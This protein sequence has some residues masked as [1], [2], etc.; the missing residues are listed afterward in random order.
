MSLH[1]EFEPH[2]WYM[3]FAI[4][5]NRA[6]AARSF[7]AVERWFAYIDNG[8]TYRVDELEAMTLDEL[9]GKIQ[10][11]HLKQHNGYGERIAKRRIEQLRVEIRA[12]RMSYGEIFELEAL[13]DYVEEDDVEILSWA[14]GSEEDA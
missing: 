7:L 9:R 4:E 12:E 2:S 8:N 14:K 3:G 5:D 13:A 10:A 11:Y 1:L 6:K